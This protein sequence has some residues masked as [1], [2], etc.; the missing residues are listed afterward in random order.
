MAYIQLLLLSPELM[1]FEELLFNTIG[2]RRDEAAVQ[3]SM[4]KHQS[5]QH[6]L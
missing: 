1:E 6:I 5:T 2:N 4:K 3:Y